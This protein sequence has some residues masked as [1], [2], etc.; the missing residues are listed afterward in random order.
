MPTTLQNAQFRIKPNIYKPLDS[1]HAPNYLQEV[2][3]TP[4]GPKRPALSLLYG[5]RF[6]MMHMCKLTSC[7]VK[8]PLYGVNFKRG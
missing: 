5:V 8:L 1:I 6:G 4:Q 3:T 7:C 2:E